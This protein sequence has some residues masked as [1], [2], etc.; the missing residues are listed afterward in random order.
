MRIINRIGT[1]ASGDVD[2]NLNQNDLTPFAGTPANNDG[3]DEIFVSQSVLYDPS[4]STGIGQGAPTGSSGSTTVLSPA[5]TAT[6]SPFV[7]NISWDA[8]V[9]SAPVGFT[10]GVTSAVQYLE[11]QFTDAV[12]LNINIGYGEVNGAALGSGTLGSS[13]SMLGSLTYTQ[14]ANA[15]TADAKTASDTTAKG[16]L[17]ASSPVTGTYWATSA[18]EKALGLLSATNAAVDGYAGFSSSNTFDYNNSDGVTAGAYDFN[19]VVLH[20]LSEV[21]GRML[22]TGRTIGTTANSYD[23]YDLFHYSSAGTRDFSA[24]TAGYFSINGGTTNLGGF[25]TSTGGDAGDWGTTMGNDAFNAFSNSGVVNSVSNAG[26][27]ALDVIGW[28]RVAASPPTG[29]SFKPATSALAAIQTTSGLAASKTIATAT[30]VGGASGDTFTYAL[31]STNVSSFTLPTAGNVATLSTGAAAVAGA[32]NGK[33]YALTVTATDTTTGGS[34]PAT[35]VDVVVGASGNDTI[36]LAT[37]TGALPMS[38]PTFVYGLAGNDTISG[39]GMT[40]NLWFDGGAGADTMTGGGG[41]NDYLYGAAAD[42]TPS[43][44]DIITNFKAAVD[45]IDLTGIGSTKLAFAGQLASTATTLSAAS[46][47]WQSSGGNTFVYVNTGIKSLSLN[48]A[49]MKIELQG[50]V[51]LADGN[52]LHN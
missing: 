20:E 12:T 37:L 8:S 28:D 31:G 49:S 14:L 23:A 48:S 33:L 26:L 34:A 11:S 52:L 30:Q 10:A 41:V 6:A 47:G 24:T 16:T 21:M 43:V 7:I 50:A 18:Q 36:Q 2:A 27:T 29:V 51:T 44:M 42:S 46:I 22:L 39:T 35:Q 9:S 13:Q 45:V 40:G 15:L 19:G 17:P 5:N 25:N 1:G 38:T 3:A 4:E 32:A